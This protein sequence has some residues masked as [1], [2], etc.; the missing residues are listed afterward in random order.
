M[1]LNSFAL[2]CILHHNVSQATDVFSV[3]AGTEAGTWSERQLLLL[4]R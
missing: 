1:F 2:T 4:Q 3:I